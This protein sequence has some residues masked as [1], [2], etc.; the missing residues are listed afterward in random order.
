MKKS[1]FKLIVEQMVK[2]ELASIGKSYMFKEQLMK[3]VQDSL[4]SYNVNDITSQEEFEQIIDKELIKV[5]EDLDRTL[6]MIEKALKAI[7]YEI[8]FKALK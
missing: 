1:K 5:S 3:I 4:A 8:F 2:R 6:S 7:P